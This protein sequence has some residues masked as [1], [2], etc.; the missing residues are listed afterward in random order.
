M[1]VLYHKGMR[2]HY[3]LP[4]ALG[5]LGH[6]VYYCPSG[7]GTW[8]AD[9]PHYIRDNVLPYIK[10]VAPEN[11]YDL[12][13]VDVFIYIF[14]LPLSNEELERKLLS[15]LPELKEKSKYVVYFCLDYWKGWLWNFPAYE[16]EDEIVRNCTHV[17][18]VSPQLCVHLS[19]RHQREVF[20]LP[21]AAPVWFSHT[22]YPKEKRHKI[23]LILGMTY[24]RDLNN[25]MKVATEWSDWDFY[26][27][28]AGNPAQGIVGHSPRGNV[29]LLMDKDPHQI[30]A[31]AQSARVAI[32]PG[33]RNWFSYYCDPAKWY[34]YHRLGLPVISI[35]I[36]H[37]RY[38]P[39][40]PHTIVCDNLDEGMK[41]FMET[42]D[43]L[44]YP[45]PFLSFH[46]YEHRASTFLE[47]LE[48]KGD[49]YGKALPSHRR[50]EEVFTTNGVE[51]QISSV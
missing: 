9:V 10:I 19:R 50:W 16:W 45:I 29:F 15:S 11:F 33:G 46:T 4:A 24:L 39:F 20:L 14:T 31:V 5:R 28:G 41:L 12:F 35:R 43:N 47:V 37:H 1:P 3:L 36:P 18:A 25:F 6:E 32:I 21:N 48:G 40:Y 2:I 17:F 49:G 42:Y 27:I 8:V 30:Y 26:W 51:H 38:T 22:T 44:T 34:I 7:W 13:P 23:A